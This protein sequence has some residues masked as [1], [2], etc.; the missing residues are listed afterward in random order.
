MAKRKSSGYRS[1]DG[2]VAHDV[3]G[4]DR[5]SKR[6]KAESTSTHFVKPAVTQ[7]D[8]EGDQY[9]EL[10]KARR[11][12]ISNFKG[13]TM[14]GIREY[15]DKDGKMLPGKKGI[16]LTVDQYSA[17]IQVLPQIEGALSKKG[18]WVPR[19]SFAGTETTQDQ[20]MHYDG[21]DDDDDD[22]ADDG[23]GNQKANIEATSDEDEG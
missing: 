6:P 17:L 15:Y 2:F 14:V 3:D 16:S 19:P 4:S 20:A 13:T 12:T 1:D 21:D 7:V 18:E 22:E 11:V 23:R 10:S 5:G 9:W 8:D